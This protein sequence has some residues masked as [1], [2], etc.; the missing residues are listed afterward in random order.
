MI[1]IMLEPDSGDYELVEFED[2]GD[3]TC[4][5]DPAMVGEVE[6][7]DWG[8]IRPDWLKDNGTI[9][10]LL[11][12]EEY[13]DT[14]LGNPHAGEK[15]IKGLSV[16]LNSRF[17]D[18]SAVDIKVVELRSEKKSKWPQSVDDRDDTRRP[19]NRQIRGA[20]HYVTDVKAEK[21]K[22][23]EKGV[24]TLD[25]ERVVAEWYLWDGERP[26]V[27]SYAK[28]GGYIAVRYND[29][30][31]Q[32]TSNKVHFRWFGVIEGKVQQNLT[33]ILEPPHY[34]SNNGRWGIH[35]DQSRNRLIFT[36]N[37]EKGIDAPLSDWGLSSQK[38]CQKQSL[39]QFAKRA[40]TLRDPSKM[41]IT[42]SDYKTNSAIAG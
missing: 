23:R 41:K 14:I 42:V 18:L 19:N 35:V 33:I 17:W 38:I 36:G 20:R 28:K 9:V 6:G 30:L 22:L 16:Y 5:I 21:G 32:P 8:S 29:E 37:G 13:P 31:F 11:G 1:W 15:E 34:Q 7:I 24:V 27:D 2:E 40:V 26:H 10:V 3:K 39:V 12:S 25:N 4:V